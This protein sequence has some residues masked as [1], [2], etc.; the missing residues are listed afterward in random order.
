MFIEFQFGNFRSFRD[1]NKFSMEAAPL[2]PNDHGL[3]EGNVFVHEDLRLLRTKAIYGSNASG[4]SNL[5]KVISA[6][7]FLVNYSVAH[8]QV[9][10]RI[11]NDRF[12]LLVDWDDQPMFFQYAFSSKE[13]IYRYGFE[14][15]ENE[16]L[17]EWLYATGS[18]GEVEY[19]FRE[20]MGLRINK[21]VFK[22]ADFFVQQATDRS[23]ELFR[24]D[25]L[26]LT[27]AGLSGNKLLSEI[28]NEIRYVR[29]ID[30]IND[31]S[32]L[33]YAM[34]RLINGS[35]SEKSAI[36]DLLKSADTNIEALEL[37][38]IV[39]NPG[40]NNENISTQKDI[41]NSTLG[42]FS[43]HIRYDENGRKVDNIIVPFGEWESEG[44]AKLFGIGSVVLASLRE[45]RTLIIDEF[46]ARFHP[47]LTLKIVELFQDSKTNP[48]NAQLI[49]AT[50]DTGLLKRANLRRDQ[51]CLVNKDSYGISSLTTL[52][53]FKGVRKDASYEKEYLNGT[54]S[55]VP[56]LDELDSVVMKN[57]APDGI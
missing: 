56:F 35:V 52:I 34:N 11:W 33:L 18:P 20:G 3:E 46:D 41:D 48:L 47:N 53:E 42:L 25:S 4:K 21:E 43:S 54:Y 23:N 10:K 29:S 16:I 49:F 24:N 32:A 40:P 30:G 8:E 19:F 9:P 36:N 26:F 50:H 1:I 27:A 37:R 55:A 13:Y 31:E 12:K 22:E 44:T 57:N 2:R 28:R 51:I 5:T 14:I 38:K 45:G 15:L 7:C 6:F 17:T 39:A